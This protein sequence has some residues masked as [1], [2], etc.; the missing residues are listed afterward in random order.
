MECGQFNKK[1]PTSEFNEESPKPEFNEGMSNQPTNQEIIYN[2]QMTEY[3]KNKKEW[4]DFSNS[5][6]PDNPTEEDY[7]DR[8]KR[9]MSMKSVAFPKPLSVRNLNVN[10]KFANSKLKTQSTL[11]S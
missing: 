1:L 3:L 6:L 2:E 7:N 9:F 10:P 11:P 4:D 8:H 5:T